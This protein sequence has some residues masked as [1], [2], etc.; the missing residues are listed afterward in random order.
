MFQ[1]YRI[2][3]KHAANQNWKRVKHPYKSIRYIFKYFFNLNPGIIQKIE[4]IVKTHKLLL[5][6]SNEFGRNNFVQYYIQ[7]NREKGV[8]SACRKI[9][10]HFR[11]ELQTHIDRM[12][13]ENIISVKLG[14]CITSSAS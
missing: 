6:N 2:D 10:T 8:R 3:E 13:K 7:M 5:K 11:N 14:L 9:L 12:L 4:N 1:I